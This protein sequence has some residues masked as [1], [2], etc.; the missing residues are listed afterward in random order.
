MVNC[1]QKVTIIDK[2]RSKNFDLKKVNYA[3]M[4]TYRLKAD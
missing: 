2:K 3:T 1:Y 4:I